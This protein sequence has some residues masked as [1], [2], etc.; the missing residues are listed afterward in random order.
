MR[1]L[2]PIIFL[3]IVA[4]AAHSNDEAS[5]PFSAS[6]VAS[7]CRPYKDALLQGHTIVMHRTEATQACTG[8][9]IAIQ[10]LSD[11]SSSTDK[12]VSLLGD[13]APTESTMVD[14]IK[15]FVRYEETHPEQGHLRFI[16]VALLSLRAAYPCP[17]RSKAQR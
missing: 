12:F 14:L 15:A 6:E 7:W 8:A 4:T 1:Q 16:D 10:Q 9:F 11:T 2:V 13:C 5:R 3:L 17:Q